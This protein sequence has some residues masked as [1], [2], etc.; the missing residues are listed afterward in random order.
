[1]EEGHKS[2]ENDFRDW[3]NEDCKLN[4]EVMNNDT[5]TRG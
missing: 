2:E 4:N 5:K 3:V 1:M